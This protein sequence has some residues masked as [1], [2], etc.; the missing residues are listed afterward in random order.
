MA[1]SEKFDSVE[2][3]Y[4]RILPAIN[5]KISEL[6]RKNIF[7]NALDIWNYCVDVNWKNKKDLRIYKLVDDILN[8]NEFELQMYVKNKNK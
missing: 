4:K 3:L 2:E 7:V 5:T 6:K 1:S 8:L